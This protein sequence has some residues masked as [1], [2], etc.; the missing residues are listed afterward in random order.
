MRLSTIT[1]LLAILVG[2]NG[3]FKETSTEIDLAKLRPLLNAV[4]PL[5][6]KGFGAP[7]ISQIENDFRAL[8]ANEAKRSTFPVVY[9]GVETELG[10]LVRKEDVDTVEIRFLGTPKLIEKIQQTMRL[11]IE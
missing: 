7:Q 4:Q 3:S 10:V 8:A 5:I 6:A 1:V 11:V 9:D 2:C